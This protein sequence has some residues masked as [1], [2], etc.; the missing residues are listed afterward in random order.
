M[1]VNQKKTHKESSECLSLSLSRKI[2]KRR[3][4]KT[5]ERTWK[6]KV[7][8]VWSNIKRHGKEEY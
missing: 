8:I 6:G 7:S 2:S 1:S 4:T 3:L 5:R